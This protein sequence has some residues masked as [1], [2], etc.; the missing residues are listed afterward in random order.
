MRRWIG[1]GAVLAGAA[2]LLGAADGSWLR[3]VSAKDHARENP[4]TL[5]ADSRAHAAAAGKQL[6]YNECAKCHGADGG[7]LYRRPPMVSDRVDQAT[8][9]DLFWLMTN[10]VPWHGMPAWMML[11]TTQR[12]QLVTYVRSLNLAEDEGSG[13]G[14]AQ[15]KGVRQ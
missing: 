8:D 4:L 10:G 11:P 12:W 2:L 9:G 5:T 6:F 3:R 13:T 15:V 14:P 7:G 1:A